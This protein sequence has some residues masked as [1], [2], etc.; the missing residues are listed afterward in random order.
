MGNVKIKIAR[1][2]AVFGCVLALG[3]GLLMGAAPAQARAAA[4]PAS[5][6]AQLRSAAASADQVNPA[7]LL[8]QPGSSGYF[9]IINAY[10]DGYC[11]GIKGG[12][13]TPGTPAVLWNCNGNKDQEWEWGNEDG[14]SGYYQ[15]V[16]KDNLCLG[17]NGG[18]D[19]NGNY[20]VAYNCLGT[21]HPDQ[22]W[23]YVDGPSG[24]SGGTVLWNLDGGVIGTNGGS[25]AENT[26]IV[27]WNYQA[28]CNNQIWI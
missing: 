8:P 3:L 22:Y 23:A 7:G 26:E 18:V 10:S 27:I 2:A 16:N 11:L 17:I 21:N 13:V 20:L 24:C 4:P 9:G 12:S 6:A 14:T 28:R 5:A 25:L 1:L 19:T 15:L